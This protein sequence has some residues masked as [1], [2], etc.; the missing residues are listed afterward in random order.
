MKCKD[1]KRFTEQ[2]ANHIAEVSLNK[3]NKKQYVYLCPNCKTYHLTSNSPQKELQYA[4]ARQWH[5][6][7]SESEYWE[8]KF[9][10]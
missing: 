9:K 6:I 10:Q 5:R 3:F 8:Q 7:K 1:K 4:K 2:E